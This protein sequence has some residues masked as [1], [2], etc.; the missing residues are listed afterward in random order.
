M[1]IEDFRYPTSLEREIIAQLLGAEFHGKSEL[2][3]QLTDFRVRVID[4]EG[5]LEFQVNSTARPAMVQKRIPVE[6]EALDDDGIHVHFLL[7]VVDGFAR[8]LEIYK[9]DSSPIKRMPSPHDLDV[10]VL[11]S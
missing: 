3:N 8:E 7:H 4:D 6:A 9:D 1:T 2:V 11:P 10:I 5:S